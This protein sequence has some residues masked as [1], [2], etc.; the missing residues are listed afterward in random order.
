MGLIRLALFSFNPIFNHPS[1]SCWFLNYKSWVTHVRE[2]LMPVGSG[3][4]FSYGSS[5]FC[6]EL[7][8]TCR[9]ALV[10]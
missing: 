6:M 3:L 5:R 8:C 4:D 9:L 10:F 7:Y 1:L 2:C